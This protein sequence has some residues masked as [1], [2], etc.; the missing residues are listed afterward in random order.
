M[1]SSKLLVLAYKLLGL[2]NGLLIGV[3]FFGAIDFKGTITLGSVMLG[4]I[5]LIIAG[6]FTVRS[7][8]ASIWREEAEGERASKERLEAILAHERTEHA[9]FELEQQELRHELKNQIAECKAQLKVAESRTDL[10]AALE[11]IRD[12]GE[13][14]TRVSRELAELI[15]GWNKS[16]V[17]RDEATHKLLA[18]IRDKL[19][20]EPIA[21]RPATKEEKT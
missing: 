17:K 10:T 8:I 14:G 1:V 18:E 9:A 13:H 21:V 11:A 12:I 15:G 2:T 3:G 7:K 20:S 5:I 6:I 4:F 16:S 19:P